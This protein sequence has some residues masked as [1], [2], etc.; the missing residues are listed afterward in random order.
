MYECHICK[1]LVCETMVSD[2]SVVKS[3]LDYDNVL[4][5][6]GELGLWHWLFLLLLVPPALLPGV[7]LVLIKFMTSEIGILKLSFMILSNQKF[8]SS[9]CPYDQ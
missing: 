6:V 7:V 2:S 8:L 1:V 4:T 3:R 5:S 9:G